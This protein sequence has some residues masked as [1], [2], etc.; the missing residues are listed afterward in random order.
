MTKITAQTRNVVD[1]GSFCIS[2]KRARETR[3]KLLGCRTLRAVAARAAL[4]TFCLSCVALEGI[5]HA[6]RT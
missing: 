3:F 2:R 4:L 5:F 6:Q 1:S